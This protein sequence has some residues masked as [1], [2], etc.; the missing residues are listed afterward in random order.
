[1]DTLDNVIG[2]HLSEGGAHDAT[3]LEPE[4]DA[5][6]FLAVRRRTGKL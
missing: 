6:L 3:V 4:K 2:Q 5:I 1:M